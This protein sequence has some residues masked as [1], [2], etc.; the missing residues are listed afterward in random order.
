MFPNVSLATAERYD[1]R[2]TVFRATGSMSTPRSGHTATLLGDGRVLV[3]GGLLTT[4]AT[5]PD[6]R[7]GYNITTT[8]TA[9]L[10]DP[11]VGTFGSVG[12]MITPRAGHAAVPLDGG[13]WLIGGSGG[14]ASLGTSEMFLPVAAN[15]PPDPTTKDVAGGAPPDLVRA[16]VQP[17]PLG[18]LKW[19]IYDTASSQLISKDERA[20]QSAD[21]KVQQQNS[22]TYADVALTDH[23]RMMVALDATAPS[24]FGLIGLRDDVRTFSWEWF[25]F[26]RPGHARKLQESGELA[27]QENKSAGSAPSQRI[28][29][30]SDV[31]LRIQRSDEPAGSM[32]WRVVILKGSSFSW[33]V[34]ATSASPSPQPVRGAAPAGTSQ[35]VRD[36]RSAAERGSA[37]AQYELGDALWNGRGVRED[38]TEAVRWFRKAAEQ[39]DVSA[40]R[41]LGL[42][43]GGNRLLYG[44]YGSGPRED[45]S[46]A[47][48]WFRKAADQ[49][50]NQGM[51][52]LGYFYWNGKGLSQSWVEGTNWYRKAAEQ[53]GSTAAMD[54]L[55][56]AYFNGK[57][58]E[59][60]AAA[61]YTW[62]ETALLL[63][64]AAGGPMSRAQSDWATALRMMAQSL[65]PA[66]VSG[67][68]K[69]A[70][71]WIAAYRL[72]KREPVSTALRWK[73]R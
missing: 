23:F 53:N 11:A 10:Y 67:A 58:V 38:D 52:A 18:T 16:A 51:M 46:E 65:T 7:N 54:K 64:Q 1:P 37:T 14:A 73:N 41:M 17:G 62:L 19:A 5:L 34:P 47:A 27:I 48:K 13:A 69:Q 39:G 44:L 45:L 36:L 30:L 42:V 31:S 68:E 28:E 26:D 66:Q 20:L 8:P 9:E 72:R 15:V 60:S 49:G 2:A 40:Q 35:E 25:V 22:T 29:F 12:A 71:D 57:G 63:S 70:Q 24:G 6:G 43:L 4:S 33:P 50:D 59:K 56:W 3:A 21:V 61:A 55:S 32:H